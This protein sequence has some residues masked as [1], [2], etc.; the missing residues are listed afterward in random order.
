MY[1]DEPLTWLE[2]FVKG[3][4]SLGLLGFAKFIF[5]LSP[6]QWWNVR[7]SGI[8]G[9][10]RTGATGRERMQQISWIAVLV[11]VVTVLVVGIA[12]IYNSQ[13]PLLTL[14]RQF[15]KVCVHGVVRPL[16]AFQKRSSMYL[17]TTMMMTIDLSCPNATAILH[18]LLLAPHL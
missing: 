7:G 4:A 13:V 5:T 14:S 8:M 15:G 18:F 11:G 16:K 3:L 10:G 6:F 17:V 9:G 12:S 1:E 2:H